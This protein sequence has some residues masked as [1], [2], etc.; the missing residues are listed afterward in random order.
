MLVVVVV[1]AVSGYEL[2]GGA[3]GGGGG[4]GR[5]SRWIQNRDR[6]QI[7]HLNLRLGAWISVSCCTKWIADGCTCDSGASWLHQHQLLMGSSACRP[8]GHPCRWAQHALMIGGR[9]MWPQSPRFRRDVTLSSPPNLTPTLWGPL[10]VLPPSRLP[11]GLC[12]S[13]HT[14]G[15]TAHHTTDAAAGGGEGGNRARGLPGVGSGRRYGAPT[16]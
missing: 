2:P 6:F 5:V 8:S 4:C 3:Q 14:A 9:C 15:S 10:Q 13:R 16:P 12:P 1:V 7:L 11:Y